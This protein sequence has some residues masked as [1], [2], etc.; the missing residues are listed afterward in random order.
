MLRSI[1]MVD[2][3]TIRAFFEL[4]YNKEGTTEKVYTF[5]TPVAYTVNIVTLLALL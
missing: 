5:H 2:K 1:Y 3:Q 4:S